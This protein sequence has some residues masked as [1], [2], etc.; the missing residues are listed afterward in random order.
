MFL[1]KAGK[2]MEGFLRLINVELMNEQNL[3]TMS[4]LTFAYIGDALYE[5]YIRTYI[6]HKYKVKV[7]EL[8][9]ISTK[10]VKAS[11]QA[12]IVHTLE[13]KLTEDEWKMVKRGRNQKTSTVAKN[14]SITDYR[15]ATGFECLLGYLYLTGKK[16]R[17]EEIISEAICII[18]AD[19]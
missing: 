19:K 1:K 10:F 4:P 15:Y 18:E 14:A 5:I 2:R 6:V 17:I 3:R 16:E 7:N 8:H 12:K 13:S 11:A 9:R